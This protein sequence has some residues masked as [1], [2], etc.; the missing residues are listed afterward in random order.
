MAINGTQVIALEEHYY[1]PDVAAS[2]GGGRAASQAN[3]VGIRE[4]LDDLSRLRLESM[5]DAGIDI[6]VISHAPPATQNMNPEMAVDLAAKA[7][8]RLREG[9]A[10][11]PSRFA[12]F[13]T[14]PLPDPQGAAEEL[15]RAVTRLGFKGALI[16]NSSNG[17]FVD[18]KRF[19]PVYERAQAL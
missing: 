9:V 11:V 6:Q 16:H 8:D 18:D 2:M 14:L 13:A 19:W 12:G 7:N 5:D 15:E 1:D 3:Q 4:R 10:A 17:V